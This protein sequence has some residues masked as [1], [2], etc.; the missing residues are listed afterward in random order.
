MEVLDQ[1]RIANPTL[2]FSV[3]KLTIGSKRRGKIAIEF[4]NSQIG[5]NVIPQ[6]TIHE[7][8]K[9]LLFDP[10]ALPLEFKQFDRTLTP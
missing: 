8:L 9:N 7:Y 2:Y 5:P 4:A 6:N 1:L 10:A 3:L